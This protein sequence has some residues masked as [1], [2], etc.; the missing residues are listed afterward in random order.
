MNLFWDKSKRKK[1]YKIIIINR[2]KMM[3]RIT[4]IFI[5]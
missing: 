3:N 1:N 4:I 5:N 2:W